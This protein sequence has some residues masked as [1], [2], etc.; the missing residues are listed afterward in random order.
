[1][2]FNKIPFWILGFV[3]LVLY[4]AHLINQVLNNEAGNTLWMCNISNAILAIAL[5]LRVNSLV[6]VSV[7]WIVLGIPIWIFD[8]YFTG[9]TSITSILSHLIGAGIGM[10]CLYFIGIKKNTWIFCVIYYLIIQQISKL[11]TEPSLNVNISHSIY[12]GFDVLF[13]A[14]WQYWLFTTFLISI[15]LWLLELIF[16]LLIPSHEL[17]KD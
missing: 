3:V 15:L 6:R 5:L 9:N 16:K 11:L 13:S 10:Y 4:I 7:P 8:I 2:K 17:T 1:M 12:K 14:Y